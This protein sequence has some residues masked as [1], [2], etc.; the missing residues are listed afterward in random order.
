MRRTLPLRATVLLLSILP[1]V[2][3]ATLTALLVRNQANALAAKQVEIIER[4]WMR[5]KR[6]ELINY[7]NLA[8]TSIGPI[9]REAGPGDA[10]AQARVKQVINRLTYG[11]DGYFFIYD[12]EGRNLVHPKQSF[13]VGKNWIDLKDPTGDL[14][15]RNLLTVAQRGGGFHAYVW[16]KPSAGRVTD[17]IAYAVALEKWGWMIGTGL[18]LDDIA[19]QLDRLRSEVEQGVDDTFVLILGV[20]LSAVA[21][22]AVTGVMITLRERRS[23]DAQLRALTKRIIDT[24][25]EERGRV[26]RE[27]HDG[28]SQLL[29]SARF[30]LEKAQ[31]E[32]KARGDRACEALARGL[33]R[34]GF[35]VREVRRISRAL[36]PS[37]LDDLGLSAA[38]ESLVEEFGRRSGVTV[39]VQ[40]AAVRKLL[41]NDAK[42]ALYRV[43]QE[44][45]TNIERHA[46]ARSVEV[47][48][49][50]RGGA[51]SMRIVDDG[52]GLDGARDVRGLGLRNMR[53]RMEQLG[54]ALEI[55]DRG[56]QRPGTP[57]VEII[58]TVPPAHVLGAPSRELGDAA[59]V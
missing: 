54:G 55:I 23:A 14:V 25:E 57:G 42:T 4:D 46:Q 22:V 34:V 5:A 37:Q 49:A 53:E 36:R 20:T 44:A 47:A 50:M 27:L 21:A 41:S 32:G 19:S 18:Y 28:I 45:L 52:R 8:L 7:M 26:A 58:A 48:L 30:A 56:A 12:F 17:K 16:D 6:E 51:C 59:H 33:E 43:A 38:I 35:A 9:Y 29:V 1:L 15:I 2:L 31:L 10:A 3:C 13:R 24:Q 39:S 40:T 11:A